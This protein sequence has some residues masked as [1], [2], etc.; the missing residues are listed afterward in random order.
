MNSDLLF[1]H[2]NRINDA[3]EAVP[4]FRQFIID[5]S[6]R[7]KLVEQDLSDEPA[8]ES[9][10]RIRTERNRLSK[11]GPSKIDKISEE[12]PKA[13][14]PYRLPANWKWVRLG[15]CLEMINGRAFKPTDW[16]PSGL[17]IVRIQNLN[18]ENAPFNYCKES[19][20]EPRHIVESGCFL[21]SWSGTPGTSFGAFIW[22]RGKAALNQHI[23]RCVQIGGAY[24]ERFLQIAINGRLDEMI[25]KAHGGVGLQHITKGKLENLPLSLP[26]L[27]EQYRIVAKVDELMA[28]CDRLGAAR[29]E[30]DNR[31]DRFT[32]TSHHFLHRGVS[33]ETI[34]TP[35]HFFLDHLQ[36][37]TVIP[38]Q[39]K[40]LRETIIKLAVRGR[41]A[42]QDPH[43]DPAPGFGTVGDQGKNRLSMELNRGWSWAAVEDVAEAR[44]GKML[45]IA[46]NSGKRFRYLRNTNV[47]WFDLRMDELKE[48]KIEE[49]EV[50][51][52]R[53][54]RG[55]VLICEGGHGIGRT[56]VW[57]SSEQDIVFQKALHRVR[58]GPA[59]NSDFFS[60]CMFVYFHE[61]VLQ[62]YFT[63]VGIPHFT[64]RALATLVFP[65]PPMSEQSR[66]VAKVKELMT[67]CDRLEEQLTTTQ[68]EKRSLLEAVLYHA[69]ND[70]HAKIDKNFA[71][72]A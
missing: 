5:L 70:S 42:H 69:L 9:L 45:D 54:C 18:N 29:Q 65:L 21:I 47:H 64:G 1:S 59:L 27:A 19:I 24:Y 71:V 20:V 44:L 52:Y 68:D 26:P 2:F 34:L 61:R 4:H 53:L 63:G 25:A 23:F 39:I 58:P 30:R 62:T 38:D 72:E 6:V 10:K 12:I 43:D 7:G 66:I 51:K 28:L 11:E 15:E 55:D 16:I 56:A 22:K 14:E 32:A 49:F 46:K 41:L 57:R 31:R 33:R 60:Y 48:L 40:Q 36:H 50:E 67:V 3:P 37:L 17:P 13:E 35:A 8:S